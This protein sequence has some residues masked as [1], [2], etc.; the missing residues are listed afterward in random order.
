MSIKPCYYGNNSKANAGVGDVCVSTERAKLCLPASRLPQ[1]EDFPSERAWEW[2]V[3]SEPTNDEGLGA[4]KRC[5]EWLLPG[6]QGMCGCP[7]GWMGG[8][9][10]PSA[11]EG[12]QGECK[13]AWEAAGLEP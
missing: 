11:H 7:F 12:E 10:R 1:K 5:E 13:W 4:M 9:R 8:R 3:G 2:V 6:A